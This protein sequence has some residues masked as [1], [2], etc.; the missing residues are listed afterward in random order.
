MTNKIEIRN[1]AKDDLQDILNI[2]GYYTENTAISF[3]FETPTI[4][5]FTRRFE[6]IS[7]IFPYLVAVC[8]G[9]V[10]GYAYGNTLI[11]RAAYDF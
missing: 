3:E 7:S 5:E 2:Y 11:A 9:K 1:A 6:S 10:V 4:E 8:D